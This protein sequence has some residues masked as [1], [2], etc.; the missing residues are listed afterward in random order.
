MSAKSYGL[1]TL[2]QCV[3]SI[4]SEASAGISMSMHFSPPNHLKLP[5]HIQEQ[6]RLCFSKN[7]TC[8]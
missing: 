6:Q 1:F 8:K 5:F 4:V 3:L 7:T 2:A